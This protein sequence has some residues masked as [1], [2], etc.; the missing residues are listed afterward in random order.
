M[1]V[2]FLTYFD[3][4][5]TNKNLAQIGSIF[6]IASKIKPRF[7][8]QFR[9]TKVEDFYQEKKSSAIPIQNGYNRCHIE[10]F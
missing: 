8:P 3:H 6:S 10:E 7:T 4:F 2:Y 5:T 9:L 1:E